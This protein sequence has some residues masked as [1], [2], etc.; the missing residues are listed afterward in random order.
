MTFHTYDHVQEL[1]N[2]RNK[3]L[4][5][6]VPC[7]GGFPVPKS[8]HFWVIDPSGRVKDFE[9]PNDKGMPVTSLNSVKQVF[10][11]QK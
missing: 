2:T 10:R 8:P 9:D 4:C 1:A 6:W 7:T 5:A 11:P 3:A